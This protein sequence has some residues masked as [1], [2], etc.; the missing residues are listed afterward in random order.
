MFFLSLLTWNHICGPSSEVN[1]D[2]PV[3]PCVQLLLSDSQCLQIDLS[4][5]ESTHMLAPLFL[6]HGVS[7]D[8][9]KKCK[10]KVVS[11]NHCVQTFVTFIAVTV[12]FFL[13]LAIKWKENDFIKYSHLLKKRITFK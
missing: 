2:L 3:A 11:Q 1:A 8:V 13:T 12:I 5:H 4:S 9:E 10:S 6:C 7:Y